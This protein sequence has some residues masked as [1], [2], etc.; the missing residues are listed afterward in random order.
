[1]RYGTVSRLWN[2]RSITRHLKK[3]TD[4][5]LSGNSPG[6]DFA[7]LSLDKEDGALFL[8]DGFASDSEAF[9]ALRLAM[10]RADNNMALSGRKTAAMRLSLVLGEDCPEQKLRKEMRA[11]GS[12]AGEN[13]WELAGGNTVFAFPGDSLSA[14]VTAF[15][16]GRADAGQE[17]SGGGEDT[18]QALSRGGEDAVRALSCMAAEESVGVPAA[19][20]I[21]L[22]TGFAGAFGAALLAEKLEDDP[23]QP[24]SG[25]YLTN[26]KHPG[27]LSVRPAAEILYMLG[28]RR[29]KDVSFGGVYRAMSELAEKSSLGISILHEA[30]PVRQDTI[31]ICEYMKENPYTLTGTGGLVA[32]CPENMLDIV[33]GALS[34]A[35]IP[36]GAAG[37]LTEEK[38]RKVY[39]RE[40]GRERFLDDYRR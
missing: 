40:S 14:T 35:G 26:A 23:E 12:F 2:D 38:A 31:E 32:I 9:P 27:G 11:A 7:I 8:A 30:I 19:G 36:F 17:H 21:V 22:V 28:I 10:L 33:S 4:G 20:D 16:C 6:E 3:K 18:M 15:S 34:A 5:I 39:S 13:G 25:S 29:M 24:F 37:V 1:M